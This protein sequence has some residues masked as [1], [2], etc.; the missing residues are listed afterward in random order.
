MPVHPRLLKAARVLLDWTQQ[1][2]ADKAGVS[3]TVVHR[4]EAGY[5]IRASSWFRIQ[6]ALESGGVVF[7]DATGDAGYGVRI[8]APLPEPFQGKINN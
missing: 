4:L 7:I 3:L 8:D 2:L 1:K 6:D 5:S